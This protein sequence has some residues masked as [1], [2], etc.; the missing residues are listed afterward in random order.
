MKIGVEHIITLCL[1][2]VFTIILD[3]NITRIDQKTYKKLSTRKIL[4]QYY[5]RYSYALVGVLFI[6]PNIFLTLIFGYHLTISLAT[7]VGIIAIFAVYPL[8]YGYSNI[9]YDNKKCSLSQNI[10]LH[11]AIVTII[12][13]FDILNL[14]T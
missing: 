12:F 11:L 2:M 8:V 3:H 4:T 9:L 10:I 1:M 7:I 13:L 14:I 5:L 6:F